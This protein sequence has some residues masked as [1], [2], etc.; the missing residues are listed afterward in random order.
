MLDEAYRESI[1]DAQLAEAE[2]EEEIHL[3]AAVAEGRYDLAKEAL[4]H[5]SDP[6]ST[7]SDG[8]TALH[9]AAGDGDVDIIKLLLR[10]GA[11][12]SR[13]VKDSADF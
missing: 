11:V 7:T 8:A 9:L 10:A 3:T 2:K 5:G 13:G 1:A 4:E 12:P 6:N